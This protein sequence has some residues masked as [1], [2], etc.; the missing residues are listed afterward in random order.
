MGFGRDWKYAFSSGV[1]SH[2]GSPSESH[3]HILDVVGLRV[4]IFRSW[5]GYNLGELNFLKIA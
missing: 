1:E 2:L 4:I 3:V 5:G